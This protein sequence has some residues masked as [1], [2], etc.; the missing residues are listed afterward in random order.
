MAAFAEAPK[1]PQ[2]QMVK[3]TL[4]WQN[5]ERKVRDVPPGYI[6]PMIT[7]WV[8]VHNP[9]HW[10]EKWWDVCW[11]DIQENIADIKYKT[12]QSSRKT[13]TLSLK[14]TNKAILEYQYRS[15]DDYVREHYQPLKPPVLP[16]GF[17]E[18]LCENWSP[19][20]HQFFH[21]MIQ[22]TLFTLVLGLGRLQTNIEIPLPK[23]D[24]LVFDGFGG[25]F[26]ELKSETP[27]NKC[28]GC[29][30]QVYNCRCESIEEEQEREYVEERD[31]DDRLFNSYP[32]GRH[33]EYNC[34]YCDN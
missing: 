6:F 13:G 19:D 14:A 29:L 34:D 7:M 21:P 2:K 24:P 11:Q 26:P 5:V 8:V 31:E 33:G 22:Q 17:Y 10:L 25:I 1:I 27:K 28:Y 15:F 18:H 20:K 4:I 12:W 9:L 23:I 32:C 16:V 3:D 30:S